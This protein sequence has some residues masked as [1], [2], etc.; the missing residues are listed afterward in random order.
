MDQKVLILLM[1]LTSGVGVLILMARAYISREAAKQ[2]AAVFAATA[3]N[4]NRD[5]GSGNLALVSPTPQLPGFRWRWEKK[6]RQKQ[7]EVKEMLEKQMKL[8]HVM[9]TVKYEDKETND[10]FDTLRYLRLNKSR[11]PGKRMDAW[12]EEF[13]TVFLLGVL[14]VDAW[15]VYL[16]NCRRLALCKSIYSSILIEDEAYNL[17]IFKVV[18]TAKFIKSCSNAVAEGVELSPKRAYGLSVHAADDT[19]TRQNRE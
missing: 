1:F 12:F 5:R 13:E 16:D 19:K 2:D 4:Y 6:F 18:V 10:M 8:L 9:A 7:E 15:K 14:K 11:V 3:A 17:R